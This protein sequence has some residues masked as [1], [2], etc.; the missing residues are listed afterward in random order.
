MRL[1]LVDDEDDFRNTLS[2]RLEKRGARVSK[3]SNGKECLSVMAGQ[4]I[5]VVVLDV[6]MPGMSGIEVLKCIKADH[7]QTEVI[8]LTGHAATRDGVEG[9]K[10]GAFDYLSKPVEFEHLFGKILQAYDKIHRER[11]KRLEAD[12]KA[13]ME[14]QMIATERLAAMGTL[15][16]GVAHEINNPL[17][18]ISEAAGFMSLVLQKPELADMPRRKVFEAALAKIGKSVE[19]ARNITHQLLGSVRK[20][21]PVLAEVNIGELVDETIRLVDKEAKNRGIVIS[22]DTDAPLNS[23]WID[24]EKI[25]QV[26]INLMTNAIQAIDGQGQVSIHLENISGGILLAVS[27]TGHGVP[28]ENRERIFEPFFSTKAPGEGTGLGLFVTRE[29][30][31]KMGGTIEIHSRLGQGTRFTVRIPDQIRVDK[32]GNRRER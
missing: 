21:D 25:R 12:F 29:I 19:R 23:I 4:Q 2:K 20:N 5:D 16:A 32:N 28:R 7:P 11:E 9:I 8:F 30:I 27:D 15:A 24:P 10:S 31:E 1:L 6:K 17:A 3:A 22:L 18:I 26:L 14:Q 13:R